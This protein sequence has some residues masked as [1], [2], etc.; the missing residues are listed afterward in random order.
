MPGG[1]EQTRVKKRDLKAQCSSSGKERETVIFSLASLVSS[2]S[3]PPEIPANRGARGRE[4]S[5]C[6]GLLPAVLAEDLV[7]CRAKRCL[8]SRLYECRT[9]HIELA[10]YG[11]PRL[12]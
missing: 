6:P 2:A 1:M 5:S 9:H 10:D 8:C 12:E 3:P 7:R 4:R 11:Y